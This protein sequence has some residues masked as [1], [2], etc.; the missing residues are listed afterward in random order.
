[1]RQ[2]RSIVLPAALVALLVACGGGTTA[3]SDQDTAAAEPAASSEAEPAASSEA[4]PAA[5]Y[6]E[7]PA[8]EAG[9]ATVATATSDA[10]EILVDGDGRS[11][12]RFLNDTQG[13]STC[14]A[15]CEA[16]WPF[17]G[18]EG[19]PQ[20]G[21][22]ADASALGTLAREDGA[23]QVTYGDWPLYYFAGDTEPGDTNGQG[24]GDV[25]YLVAPDGSTIDAG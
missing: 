5:G 13:A 19:D 3:T 2:L 9:A 4:E 11:L 8:A 14:T 1:M 15:D 23:T 21:E 18:S 17:L 7:E 16:N 12:Y 25:W 24:V 20:A 10:G 22:G 6:G